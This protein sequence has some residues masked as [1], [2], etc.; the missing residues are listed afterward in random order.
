M[1]ITKYILSL[2]AAAGLL[3]ACQEPEMVQMVS[4]EDVVA[5]VLHELDGPI[6]ITPD[7][8]DDSV[9]VISWEPA[10]FGVTT[11]VDYVLELSKADGSAK[12]TLAAGVT[13][14]E[15]TVAY[16]DLNGIVYADFELEAGIPHDLL[17]TVGA[18]VG[19]TETYWSEPMTITVTATAAAKVYPKLFVVG[20][21]NGWSHDANQY[22]FDFEGSDN[23][24]EGMVDFGEDHAANEFK[25]TGGAWGKDEHSMNGAHDAETKKISL[26]VGGG[27]N[28]YVY[29]AKRYY[30]LTF[31]RTPDLTADFSFDQIGVIGDFNGWGADVVMQ[32]NPA[33]QKFYADV[34][35]PADG[36]FKFRA[37][38][39]WDV[40][41][42]STG[43]GVLDSG[44]NIPVKAGNYRVYLNMNDKN[45]MTYELNAAAYGTEEDTTMGGGTTEPDPEPTPT[46]GWG[47]V[48][49]YNGWGAESDIM[50]ASDGTYLV[51]KGV[52]LSGQ[53]K[54]R[55]DGGWDVNFGAPGD[56]EPFELTPNVETELAAGGKNFTIAEGTYDV[57]LD[58]ANAKAWFINDGSYPGGGAAPEAS[59]W[60]IVGV[61]NGWAAP[62]VT[63]YKTS[64]DGLFVAYNVAMPDGG[65]KIRANGE[66]N[67]AKNYGLEA[68]GAVEVDHWYSVITSGGSGDMSLTAGNYDIWFD[69]NNTKVYIMTPGKAISE[70]Q[71]GTAG[72]GSTGGGEET[73]QDWYLVGNFNGWTAADANYKMTAEG[74]WYVF[75]NFTADGDGVKFVADENWAVNRGGA[76]AGAGQ[77]IALTQ[78]GDNMNVAA[79][80]YDVYLSKDGSVA[81]FMTPGEVPAAPLN[82]TWYL[83]GNFNG[84]TVGDEN[85]KLTAENGWYV[86]KNFTADGQG[87]KFN[88]GNWDVNRGGAFVAANEAIAVEQNGA[89]MMIAAGTYDVYLNATEDTAYFMEPGKTPEN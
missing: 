52:S 43:S 45:K 2:A 13:K 85:Y 78:G 5:P 51:A 64:T 57:Y 50:L 84:W 14:T 68:A 39:G 54:F 31:T 73:Q 47:L 89:D 11:Q 82:G 69:L 63:M 28:I 65:F 49:E 60:G 6:V 46:L 19:V 3:S 36:G 38:A 87:V 79:G 62:D 8:K 58:E 42:G 21:Y 18:S 37:D 59:E 24:Y 67:D 35:F 40:N 81:Y 86:F 80:T 23:S 29:Q 34:E 75:K 7:N 4:P 26:V 30:H 72:S 71:E 61:V 83:V 1:K 44:D 32:F 70:A 76:F 25:I 74:D 56:V 15:A 77:A 88:A 22:I 12:K 53:F 9:A 55:K 33:T 16:L 48:G 66:W 41:W 20:S 10:D 17:L 27:D